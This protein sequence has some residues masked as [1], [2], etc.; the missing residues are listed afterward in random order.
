M[1]AALQCLQGAVIFVP[2]LSPLQ[3][4][5]SARPRTSCKAAVPN[6]RVIDF[7]FF[8]VCLMCAA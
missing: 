6:L 7:H 5:N 3:A 1:S 4:V 8:I 2:V